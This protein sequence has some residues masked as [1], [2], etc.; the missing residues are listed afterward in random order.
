MNQTVAPAGYRIA[1]YAAAQGL[2]TV[3]VTGAARRSA[4]IN[5]TRMQGRW[6]LY[7][8]DARGMML[9][10]RKQDVTHVLHRDPELR[11]A[12]ADFLGLEG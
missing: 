10:E 4:K 11:R 1:V 8:V 5:N 6:Y 12:I 9:G 7:E 3:E 2:Y